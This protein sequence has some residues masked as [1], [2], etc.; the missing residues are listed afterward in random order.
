[1]TTIG[2]AE[3]LGDLCFPL[4]NVFIAFVLF[5]FISNIINIDFF[6]SSS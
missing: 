6:I 5:I 1:M 2:N 4:N 3:D